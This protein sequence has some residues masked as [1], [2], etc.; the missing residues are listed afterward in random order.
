LPLNW[1]LGKL[2]KRRTRI[3]I[4]D[5]NYIFVIFISHDCSK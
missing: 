5:E 4:F 3:I 2:E 1:W